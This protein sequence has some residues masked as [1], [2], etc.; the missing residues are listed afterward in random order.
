MKPDY[1]K[2]SAKYRRLGFVY[3]KYAVRLQTK[4]AWPNYDASFYF[5]LQPS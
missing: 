4:K 1:N 3:E 2:E 5:G